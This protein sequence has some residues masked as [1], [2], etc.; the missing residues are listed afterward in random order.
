[1]VRNITHTI[2]RYKSKKKTTAVL[3]E[4]D[5]SNNSTWDTSCW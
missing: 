2:D 3:V 5:S 4:D 1:M